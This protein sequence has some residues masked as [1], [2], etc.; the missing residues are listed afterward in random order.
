[1]HGLS[2]N[3]SMTV[4]WPG[5]YYM[6]LTIFNRVSPQHRIAQEEILGPLLSVIPFRDEGEANRIA[7]STPYGLTAIAWTGGHKES[8]SGVEGGLEGLEAHTI[9]T[10]A[11]RFV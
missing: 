8:G 10:A 1:M 7:N 3:N 4:D 2:P 5:D 11:Q 9:Q 6:P